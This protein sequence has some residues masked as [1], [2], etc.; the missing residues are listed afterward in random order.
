MVAAGLD[1]VEEFALARLAEGDG[2]AG[3]GPKIALAMGDE[4]VLLDDLE[5]AKGDAVFIADGESPVVR[6]G[7]AWVVSLAS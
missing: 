2:V 7:E 6:A 3:R 1:P 5:L 4:G